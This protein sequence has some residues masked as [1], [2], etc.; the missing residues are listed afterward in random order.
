M[1]RGSK[2]GFFFSEET[3]QRTV[4]AEPT[5]QRRSQIHKSFFAYVFE[6]AVPTLLGYSY[7]EEK[8]LV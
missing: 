6:E 2:E 3:K 5:R 1:A 4:W 8:A 7:L